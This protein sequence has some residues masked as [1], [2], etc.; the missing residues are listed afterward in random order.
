[1]ILNKK[2]LHSSLLFAVGCIALVA[3]SLVSCSSDCQDR[4]DCAPYMPP[5]G[6]SSS[7]SS[8]DAGAPDHGGTA[9]ASSGGKSGGSAGGASAG[10]GTGAASG[11]AGEGGSSAPVPCAGACAAPTPVCDESDDSCVECLGEADCTGSEKKCDTEARECAEC[12]GSEHCTNPAAAKCAGGAC[13]ECEAN[14][15]C[16]HI[17]GKGVCDS[18]TCVECTV[19]DETA[20]QGKSCSPTTKACTTTSAGSRDLCEPCIADSECIGGNQADPDARCVAMEFQGTARP[21]G[22]C[23]KRVAK[24]CAR[25][26][27]TPTTGVSLSGAASEQYCGIDEDSTRCEAVLDL[28]ASMACADGMDISCGCLRDQNGECTNTGAGGVCRT[29]GV[30]ANQCT[31]ACGVTNDCPTGKTCTAGQPYCH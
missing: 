23:L 26:F 10:G 27:Q 20:C 30:N 5:G 13:V 28:L 31:Y 1:M 18:G 24:T 4:D 16:G 15:D 3:P 22:F 9:G 12:L 14:V 25:P 19:A 11:G 7:G 2:N 21:G 8:G 6:G 29:V 17:E